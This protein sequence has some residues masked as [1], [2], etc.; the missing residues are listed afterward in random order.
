MMPMTSAAENPCSV[1]PP[2]IS[3]NTTTSSVT[4][5]VI[6]VRDSVWLMDSSMTWAMAS[7]RALRARS[8]TR[9]NTMTV[10]FSE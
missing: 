4:S 7:L 6:K 10:S 1:S 9:S 8:R 3:R 5:L 2:K